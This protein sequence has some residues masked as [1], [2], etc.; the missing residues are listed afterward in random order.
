MSKLST[1]FIVALFPCILSCVGTGGKSQICQIDVF[2]SED[3]VSVDVF[4]GKPLG[5]M[6]VQVEAHAPAVPF[7]VDEAF[8][9][10]TCHFS[11]TSSCGFIYVFSLKPDSIDTVSTTMLRYHFSLG[12]NGRVMLMT[13]RHPDG[14]T[15]ALELLDNRIKKGWI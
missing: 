2:D 12:R 14:I 5:S 11:D 4:E 9:V 15:E 7:G 10:G 8:H 3:S 1:I 6:I 13:A